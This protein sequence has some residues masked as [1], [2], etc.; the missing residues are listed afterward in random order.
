MA[1]HQ[2]TASLTPRTARSRTVCQFTMRLS[3]R[4]SL[5]L[6]PQ[7]LEQR[8]ADAVLGMLDGLV[9]QAIDAVRA[10]HLA[11][12]LDRRLAARRIAGA[13]VGDIFVDDAALLELRHRLV[14]G[15]GIRI[16][17][18]LDQRLAPR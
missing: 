11:D 10:D 12:E 16:L 14:P 7:D 17:E 15:V 3:R 9:R 4:A 18:R 1:K 8:A 6:G 2:R 13:E 5:R